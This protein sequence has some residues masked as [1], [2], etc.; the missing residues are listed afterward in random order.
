MRRR[1]TRSEALLW[2]ALSDR[3]AGIVVRRQVVLGRHIV[4]FYVA[5][6]RLVI[7]VDGKVHDTEE[8][9]RADAAR[10]AELAAEYG[11]RFVRV[12]AE[13]V[14]RDVR[15]AVAMILAALE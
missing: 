14:E 13:L 6:Y 5:A 11:V 7:E 4:D 10:E 9:R 15:A 1:P 3:R 8:A 12:R 2:G